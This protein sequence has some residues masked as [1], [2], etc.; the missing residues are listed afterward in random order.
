MDCSDV[1][2]AKALT[3][4]TISSEK[5][6]FLPTIFKKPLTPP[7][8]NMFE[9]TVNLVSHG[10]LKVMRMIVMTIAMLATVLVMAPKR[11]L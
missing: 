6:Y 3:K 7:L 1:G 5:L 9:K 8:L 10:F 2:Q 4:F 11:H